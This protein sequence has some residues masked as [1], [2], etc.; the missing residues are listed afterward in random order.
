[1]LEQRS[2][3]RYAE[4]NWIYH[5]TAT[6]PDD[7]LFGSLWGLNNTGQAVIGDAVGTADVDI[8]APEAWDHNR[9]SASTVVG[10]VDSGVAWE[11]PDLTPN[12]WTDRV[13]S[14]VTLSTTI[15]TAAS[16]TSAAGLVGGAT[17]PG[18]TR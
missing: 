12:V 2:D 5:A 17:T 3:V 13:R 8:D 10:V 18:T 4:P 14:L 6:T 7:P 11:H 1:M 16:M 9:G 15:A